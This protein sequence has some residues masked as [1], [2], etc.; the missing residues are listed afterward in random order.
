MKNVKLITRHHSGSQDRIILITM[1][2]DIQDRHIM[3]YD[4]GVDPTPKA[5]IKRICS[6][7][8][9]RGMLNTAIKA[10]QDGQEAFFMV[11]SNDPFKSQVLTGLLQGAGANDYKKDH[12]HWFETYDIMK[13]EYDTAMQLRQQQQ[14][15]RQHVA[16]VENRQ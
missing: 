16:Y 14:A 13:K 5:F 9:L 3:A 8:V 1:A 2:K 15:A 12:S 11:L 4:C 6:S 10:A 7:R